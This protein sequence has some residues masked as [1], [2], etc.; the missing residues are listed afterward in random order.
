MTSSRNT[1]RPKLPQAR[2]N[3][4]AMAERSSSPDTAKSLPAKGPANTQYE[5]FSRF[6]GDAKD[7]SN[8]IELWDAIPKYAVSASMQR[9]IRDSGGRL[10]MHEY[11]FVYHP[12]P[13]SETQPI[14]CKMLIQ[15]ASISTTDGYQD[16]YPSHDEALIEEIIKKFFADQAH[17]YHDPRAGESWVYFT[18]GMIRRELKARGRTRSVT[19]IKCS[20][21]ILARAVYEV[22]F[23]GRGRKTL[24]Y[25]GAVLLDLT[26]V[27]RED[28]LDDPSAQWCARLPALISKSVDALTYRQFNY[29]TWMVL[30]SELAQWLHRRLSHEYTN[31]HITAPYKILYSTIERDSGL[32]NHSRRSENLKTVEKAFSELWGGGVLLATQSER[33][34][35]GRKIEDV[36]YTLT[37]ANSFVSEVKAANA[38]ARD[39]RDKAFAAAINWEGRERYIERHQYGNEQ[40]TKRAENA[41]RDATRKRATRRASKADDVD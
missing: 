5:L 28:Y 21:D 8:T 39:A 17:G 32:L 1:A 30:K 9:R 3:K 25:T 2:R 18:L 19:E 11:D 26:R 31:A 16:F 36:L 20:L 35:K 33:R 13:R 40:K 12:A 14:K 4:Q 15:P 38:R 7:L 6:F 10:P 24:A 34:V 27:T 37:P 22:R 23:S 29:G 41:D